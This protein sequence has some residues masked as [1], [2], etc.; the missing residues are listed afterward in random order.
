VGLF[1]GP[2]REGEAVLDPLRR[3]GTPLFEASGIMPYVEI[4]SSVDALFPAGGR[5]YMKSHFMDDVTP[6]AAAA[7]LEWDALAPT[8]ESLVV[9]R[10]LGGAVGRVTPQESAFP[11][12]TAAYNLS[13]DAGWSDPA[14]DHE[15][16]AWARDAWDA[17]RPF[18]TGGV[19]INFSGLDEEADELRDGVFGGAWP[20]SRPF[21]RPTIRRASSR[22]PPGVPEGPVKEGTS[23]GP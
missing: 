22:P 4:Q 16:V 21:G 7:I 15:A 10:T 14:L 13:I 6:E 11:H 18:A 1:A 5:Y 9:L 20:G 23:L 2:A 17:T 19:Y 3:L 12:R 8:P